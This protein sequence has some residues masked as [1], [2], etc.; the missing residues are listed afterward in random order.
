MEFGKVDR[1]LMDTAGNK[2]ENTVKTRVR[3]IYLVV[4]KENAINSADMWMLTVTCLDFIS[5]LHASNCIFLNS[6][7]EKTLNTTNKDN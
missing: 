5:I 7:G 2:T 6:G 4:F 3:T 1:D